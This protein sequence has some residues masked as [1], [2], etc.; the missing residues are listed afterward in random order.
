MDPMLD[1]VAS[2]L[3]RLIDC[4]FGMISS[5]IF[6]ADAV[7]VAEALFALFANLYRCS[8]TL[9]GSSY[10]NRPLYYTCYKSGLYTG[11]EKARTTL[12]HD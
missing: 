4:S 7:L 11:K 1:Q 12:I 10:E 8:L 2:F 9:D 5:L 6:L 3:L